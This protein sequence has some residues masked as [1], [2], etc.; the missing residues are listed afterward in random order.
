MQIIT[1]PKQLD[2]TVYDTF[3]ELYE[4]Y[5]EH[6]QSVSVNTIPDINFSNV[7]D[8]DSLGNVLEYKSTLITL[9]NISIPRFDITYQ[10]GGTKQEKSPFIDEIHIGKNDYTHNK[11]E[12]PISNL[13]K[14]KIAALLSEKFQSIDPKRA[15]KGALSEEQHEL[16][17]IHQ[18]TLSRLEALNE[19]LI[20]ES[21]GFRKKLE[22][23]YEK[24]KQHI[25]KYSNELLDAKLSEI[26]EQRKLLETKIKD[27]DDRDNTHVRRQL[28]QNILAEIKNRSTEF[29]LT[30]GTNRLRWPI[31]LACIFVVFLF[32]V[33]AW[34]YGKDILTYLNNEKFSLSAFIILTIKQFAFTMASAGTAIF[35]IKWLNRWF[36]QHSTAEFNI[37]QFQLDIERSS[38]IV[39]TVLEW[40]EEKKSEFPGELLNQLTK[41]LFD[42]EK[43]KTD[44]IKHPADH[45]A[46]ALLGTAS[47]VKLKLGN[48]KAEIDF[49]GKQLKKSLSEIN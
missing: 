43:T 24:K 28:R 38:W 6:I 37:K 33:A 23:E 31:H 12:C 46:S 42:Y 1:I 2:Q 36:E 22:S 40:N 48:E 34:F 30:K 27:I 47:N 3:K 5:R 8:D 35:Y 20:V 10:R 15:I 11:P 32:G 19:K 21:Q 39:E 4:L 17:S 14:L 26:E 41:N 9:F 49:T 16:L 45:L 18:E 25:E 7:F 13:D 44:P 29:K